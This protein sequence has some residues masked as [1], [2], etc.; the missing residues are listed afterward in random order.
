[1]WSVIEFQ[2]R[3]EF[4]DDYWQR[5]NEKYFP[6]WFFYQEKI[7]TISISNEATSIGD[8]AFHKFMTIQTVIIPASVTYVGNYAFSGSLNLRK[9]TYLGKI[10]PPYGF[11]IFE[12]SQARMIYVPYDYGSY[13][14]CSYQVIYLPEAVTGSCG[15]TVMFTY[16]S[17]YLNVVGKGSM[18]DYSPSSLPSWSSF[19]NLIRSVDFH[20]GISNIGDYSFF[21]CINLDTVKISST[22]TSLGSHAFS[23]CSNLKK[24]QIPSSVTRLKDHLFY[25]CPELIDVQIPNSVNFIGDSSFSFCTSLKSISIPSS[26]SQVGK[27]AFS[28]CMNLV[29]IV[30]P[31]T[32]TSIS[33]SLFSYCSS[34]KNIVLPPSVTHLGDFSFS[35]LASLIRFLQLALEFFTTAQNLKKRNYQKSLER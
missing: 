25:K 4:S 10:D 23:G 31:E 20:E 34:L 14:F 15:Q 2:H 24:I 26:V 27:S 11:D 29:D 33:D 5:P 1:M 17:P 22:I 21:E 28:Y 8:Y 12:G 30:F 35:T 18:D 9:V 7:E 19:K 6:P 3:R 32:I 16:E 13:S